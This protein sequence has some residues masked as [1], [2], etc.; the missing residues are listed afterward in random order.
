MIYK[1][2]GVRPFGH[3]TPEYNFRTRTLKQSN[4]NK[5]FICYNVL[6]G[7]FFKYEVQVQAHAQK[8]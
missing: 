6:I 1:V 2:R 3:K 8:F 4:Q 7:C 5:V